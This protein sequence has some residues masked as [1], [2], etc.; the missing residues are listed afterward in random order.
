MTDEDERGPVELGVEA[1][2]EGVELGRGKY[3]LAAAVRKLARVIDAR[4]E[5]EPAS[6]TAKA[7]ETLRITMNQIHSKDS[8]DPQL[9]QQLLAGLQTPNSGGS[10]VPPALRYPPQS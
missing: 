5:D 2:L 3:A 4:G 1:D 9:V 6:Q 10:P 8:H 7:I